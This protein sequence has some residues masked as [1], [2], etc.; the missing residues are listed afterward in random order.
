M[1]ISKLWKFLIIIFIVQACAVPQSQDIRSSRFNFHHLTPD[2]LE[3]TLW[4]GNLTTN[5]ASR[6]ERFMAVYYLG[7]KAGLARGRTKEEAIREV[8]KLTLNATYQPDGNTVLI[9]N[10]WDAGLDGKN[11]L[12]RVNARV[13]YTSNSSARICMYASTAPNEAIVYEVSDA[14]QEQKA[15]LASKNTLS[16]A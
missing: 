5:I 3:G 4:C 9:Q 2:M 6:P 15:G 10:F 8:K 7:G 14:R 16:F 12:G 1:K 13:I 11:G